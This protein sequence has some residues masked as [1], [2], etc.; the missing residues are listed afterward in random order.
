M[1]RE[2]N[3]IPDGRLQDGLERFLLGE[4]VACVLAVVPVNGVELG[5]RVVGDVDE[6]LDGHV[7]VTG[8][9]LLAP[10]EGVPAGA[11]ARAGTDGGDLRPMVDLLQPEIKS[12]EQRIPS[13]QEKISWRT[14]EK[15]MAV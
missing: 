2:V 6:E 4:F 14:D 12:F 7:L 15:Y 1:A 13:N 8:Q 10:V 9:V 11:V 3:I 5:L